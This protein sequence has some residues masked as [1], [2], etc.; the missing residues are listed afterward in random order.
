MDTAFD[1]LFDEEQEYPFA[2]FVVCLG[3][4][5]ILII[6]QVVQSC[7]RD[8]PKI[9]VGDPSGDCENSGLPGIYL[10]IVCIYGEVFYYLLSYLR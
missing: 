5:I 4:L 3:F 1:E 9:R 2:Y 6:E 10:F 8:K 7:I